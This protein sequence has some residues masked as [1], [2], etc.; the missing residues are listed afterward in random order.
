MADPTL[1]D[2]EALDREVEEAIA[3][4]RLNSNGIAREDI[5]SDINAIDTEDAAGEPEQSKAAPSTDPLRGLQHLPKVALLGRDAIRAKADE[6][7]DY[8]WQDI[9]VA[10]TIVL[11][12][13]GPGEGKTTLL[14][15]IL[16]A[17][18]SIAEDVDILMRKVTRAPENKWIVLI[19][20]EHGEG[21]ASRKIVKSLSVLAVHN[22]ALKR[23]IIVARKAVRIGSPEWGDVTELVR[24]GLV[25]DIALDT[26]A[27]CAPAD[28]NNEQEQVAIFDQVAATIDAAPTDADKPTVW[29]VAHTRKNGS[30]ESVADVSGSAQRAGQVDSVLMVKGEKL[31]GR[32]VSSTVTFAKLREEPDEYPAPVT[33]AITRGDGGKPRL[34][35]ADAAPDTDAPLEAQIL[36]VLALGPKTKNAL[37]RKLSRNKSDI[38]GALT[39]LFEARR[40]RTTTVKVNRRDFKAFDLRPV[41][42]PSPGPTEPTEEAD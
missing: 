3:N 4:G 12:A 30:G 37:S 24:R 27:R 35:L 1:A 22:L 16:A 23:I 6:P 14:F 40:I 19:E 21:S 13:G 11:L 28:A 8:V 29:V 18:M 15:L 2:L 33:F 10:G 39:A 36:E 9:A 32:T 25:S 41:A 7:V 17:R 42:P 5:A 38:D 34:V 31:A 26:I 20:G